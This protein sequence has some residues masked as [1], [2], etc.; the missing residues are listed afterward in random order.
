M[1]TIGLVSDTH[2]P[3]FG[4]A[5]PR[6]LEDGR[7]AAKVSRILHL[8]DFTDALAVGL[9]EAIAPRLVVI[10]DEPG[11]YS[12]GTHAVRKDGHR[13][14]FGGVEIKK[15]YVSAHLIPVYSHPKLLKGV[16]DGLRRR[17]QGKSCFNFKAIDGAMGR[18]LAS[19]VATSCDVALTEGIG[20]G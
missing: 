4:R 19:L 10:H 8:G 16:S 20:A 18:E 2:F 7:R 5:L 1:T 14:W 13:I 12:L 11:K 17:M 15:N 3:R 9:F 6:A